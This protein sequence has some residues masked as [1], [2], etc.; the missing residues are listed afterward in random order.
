[1]FTFK[2]EALYNPISSVTKWVWTKGAA[3]FTTSL[4][5]FLYSK[6]TQQ[7]LDHLPAMANVVRRI[8]CAAGDEIMEHYDPS[9]YVGEVVTKGD[10]SPVTAA[11]LAADQIIC[12]QLSALFPDIPVLTEEIYATLD[13]QILTQAPHYWVVDPLDGTK[14]FARG[15]PDF[16][17]NIALVHDHTPVMGVIYAPALGEGYVGILND[18]HPDDS[19]TYR[20]RDDQDQDVPVSVRSVPSAGLTFLT[21]CAKW[22]SSPTLD[23]M[24]RIKM[25]KHIRRS[26][27]IKY[28]DL[29]GARA[30]LVVVAHDLSY[31]D[32][33]AAEA[34]L[35]AAGG[36]MLDLKGRPLVYDRACVPIFK[37]GIIAGTSEEYVQ[38]L[39]RDIIE[40]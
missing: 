33:A 7:L 4:M 20:F 37:G 10:N 13:P 26:S 3:W 40:G 6:T 19:G 38:P 27:S 23:I 28:C 15:D 5:T 25:R 9:G 16:T 8:A 36:C 31:W 24:A 39:L 21:S 35:C 29:A 12:D 30:D 18:V 11:D 14:S 1:M 17:V 2:V 32:V 34:I 22:E